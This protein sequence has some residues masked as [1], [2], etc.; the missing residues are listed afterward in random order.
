M[1]KKGLSYILTAAMLLGILFFTP[2]T[3]F[4]ADPSLSYDQVAGSDEMTTV[5]EVGVEGMLP[6]YAE[7]IV[8]GVYDIEMESSSSM[9]KVVSCRLTVS[10]GE[11]TAVLT[12][13]GTGYLCLYMG[14][15]TEAAGSDISEYI[16]YE[17]NE[18]GQYTFTV[19]V[20]ALDQAIPCA[21]FSRN[22]E[23]WYDR[24]ILFEAESLPEE[25]VLTERPDYDALRKA[26][27]EKRIEAMR[28]ENETEET[29][30]GISDGAS[31]EETG[32]T[33]KTL[34]NTSETAEAALI[35]MEDGEY[36]V[37]VVLEGGSGKASVTSPCILIVED[38]RAYAR[39]EWSSSNYDYMIIGG[40][41][42][43]PVN[44]EGNSVFEIP[45]IVFDE[46]MNVIADTTAMSTPHEIEYTLTFDSESIMD[47]SATP[48]EA[49]K[50]VVYM[51][52][53]II[54]ACIV[55]SIINKKRRNRK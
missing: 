53:L 41:K 17:E 14:T 35:E 2:E 4:A 22:K 13:S 30:T 5:D 31:E 7:D 32:T 43:L 8:D 47:K 11:M 29:G 9:F 18:E 36:A 46:P 34:G 6:I 25:A 10:D 44:D 50:R 20:E 42:Y 37:N 16:S 3:G 24:S 38:G 28:A 48:Q 55:V 15:G 12:M 52:L 19:P 21:A 40:E 51:V 39:I 33:N 23:K 49:A 27:K 1:M 45:I 26:A 54:A